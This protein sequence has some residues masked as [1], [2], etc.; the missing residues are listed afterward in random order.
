MT[1]LPEADAIVLPEIA[2]TGYALVLSDTTFIQH[3]GYNNFVHSAQGL[4]VTPK[5]RPR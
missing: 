2:K 3:R 4:V 5:K 1:C